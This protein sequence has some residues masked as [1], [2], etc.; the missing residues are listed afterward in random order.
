MQ[1]SQQIQETDAR[2][3]TE[4][5]ANAKMKMQDTG[6][7]KHVDTSPGPARNFLQNDDAAGNL[8]KIS[9]KMRTPQRKDAGN[10]QP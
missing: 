8:G 2:K 6:T 5:F 7:K 9:E 1:K 4:E 10:L 3:P